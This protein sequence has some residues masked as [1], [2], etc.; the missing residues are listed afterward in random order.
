MLNIFTNS[1][2]CYYEYIKTYATFKCSL[3]IIFKFFTSVRFFSFSVDKKVT[4]ALNI[5][6]KINV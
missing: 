1:L 4:C 6:G 2:S 3:F 5:D